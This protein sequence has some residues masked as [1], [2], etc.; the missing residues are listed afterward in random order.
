MIPGGFFV[1]CCASLATFGIAP[2]PRGGSAALS[3]VTTGNV[4]V[5]FAAAFG[6]DADAVVSV[7]KWSG[8]PD[9]SEGTPSAYLAGVWTLGGESL[10]GIV[11]LL[12]CR[13]GECL[14]KTRSLG[15]AT[16][17]G[18]CADVDL[19]GDERN[20]SIGSVCSRSSLNLG[21]SVRRPALVIRVDEVVAEASQTPGSGER[22]NADGMAVSPHTDARVMLL[23]LDLTRTYLVADVLFMEPDGSGFRTETL[24][25]RKGDRGPLNVL[26]GRQR[27]LPEKS[28]CLK[29][30]GESVVFH[31]T[32]G[33]YFREEPQDAPDGSVPG[34]R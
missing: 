24:T 16:S 14:G 29:P 26:M 23:S 30:S 34:C 2:L 33:H 31:F 17:L 10:A 13:P 18:L 22:G 32:N 5:D 27:M 21:R 6:V 3:Q 4:T 12:P 7:Q 11:P 28:R 19:E 1:L 8:Q 20:V 9:G 15:R 25:L